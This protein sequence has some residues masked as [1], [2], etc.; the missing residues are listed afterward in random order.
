MILGGA[1]YSRFLRWKQGA[2]PLPLLVTEVSSAH[3][4]QYARVCEHTLVSLFLLCHAN[5]ES[6]SPGWLPVTGLLVA[7]GGR[8]I[9]RPLQVG[10]PRAYMLK[11]DRR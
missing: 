7:S 1:S 3:T 2:Q 4:E 6:G 5:H 11:D 9:S 8:L 10:D